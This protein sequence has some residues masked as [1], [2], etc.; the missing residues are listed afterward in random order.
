MEEGTT[1]PLFIKI[2]RYREVVH[3]IQQLRSFALTLRD[4][5]D[6]LAEIE[7]QLHTGISISHKAL[8]SFN[9]II[10]LLDAKLSHTH[11]EDQEVKEIEKEVATQTPQQI[12][13]YVRNINQEMQKLK[14]DLQS[15]SR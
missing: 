11:M 4:A 12:E 6:S 15:I 2:D 3:N 7:R 8:D 14:K 5:L 10:S 1:A 13:V 9:N